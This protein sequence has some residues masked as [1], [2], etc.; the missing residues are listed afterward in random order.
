MNTVLL[1]FNGERRDPLSDGLHPGN[2][3]RPYNPTL[4]RFNCPD[5]WSPFGPGGTHPWA[6]CEGD[7]INR[8]DPSGHFSWQVAA[9][10]GLGLLGMVTSLFTAGASLAATGSLSAALAEASSL[11][12][13]TTGSALFADITGIASWLA[14][15]RQSTLAPTL[16][17]LSFSTGMLSFVSGLALAGNRLLISQQEKKLAGN[18][19]SLGNRSESQLNPNLVIATM[20][21]ERIETGDRV[22]LRYAS[23]ESNDKAIF[24]SHSRFLPIKYFN[25]TAKLTLPEGLSVSYYIRRGEKLGSWSML[26]IY[27]R[28]QGSASDEVMP[29]SQTYQGKTRIENLSL[30]PISEGTVSLSMM[31]S[32]P[33]YSYDLIVPVQPAE[34]RHL[35]DLAQRY[36]YHDL[37]IL[38]CRARRLS[39]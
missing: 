7:P 16:G 21:P 1:S 28:L 4:M 6:W 36:H 13:F 19:F 23:R 27:N 20:S 38:G 10:I 34:T 17:W 26:R 29:F 35:I 30:R 24:V 18:L 8:A 32:P 2:G 14:E 9:G 37:Q 22:F 33:D 5:S 12:L 15:A 31:R 3:L 39:N 25:G 11:T